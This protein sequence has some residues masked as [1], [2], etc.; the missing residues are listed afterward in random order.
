[1]K[2]RINCGTLSRYGIV[3]SFLYEARILPAPSRFPFFIGHYTQEPVHLMKI[4][5]NA[6]KLCC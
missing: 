6:I 3:I 4:K 1:M 2:R 5:F